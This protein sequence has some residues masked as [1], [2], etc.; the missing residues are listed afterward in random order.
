MYDND[1]SEIKGGH[2]VKDYEGPSRE[3]ALTRVERV[4]E[5]KKWQL[6]GLEQL[7]K[8]LEK[9]EVGSPLEVLL[10]EMTCG[11]NW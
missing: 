5:D 10:W 1:C 11:R 4:I 3:T 9:A 8:V 6:A 2:R 7:K